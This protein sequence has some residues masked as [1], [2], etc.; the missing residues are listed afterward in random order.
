MVVGGLGII[1][2]ISG[3]DLCNSVLWLL[4]MVRRVLREPVR[5]IGL[6]S[7][8]VLVLVGHV[9]ASCHPCFVILTPHVLD[10]G[11]LSATV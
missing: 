7:A 6:P 9:V 1:G 3:C 8:S 11:V 10:V 4:V 5:F 2:I